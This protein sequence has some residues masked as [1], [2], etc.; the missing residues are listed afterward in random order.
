[1]NIR[2]FVKN[3][4]QTLLVIV[5]LSIIVRAALLGVMV[6]HGFDDQEEG[7][8]ARSLLNGQGYS[9]AGTPTAHKPPLYTF[10]LT[11][12]FL[13]FPSEWTPI[14]YNS[15]ILYHAHVVDQILK[16]II[17]ALTVL[18]LYSLGKKVFGQPTGLLGAFLFAINPLLAVQ[19]LFPG[20][21]P[22]DMLLFTGL[23]L[24]FVQIIQ[25][26]SPKTILVYSLVSAIT[27][28]ENPVILGFILPAQVCLFFWELR[29]SPVKLRLQTLILPFV[30]ILVLVTPWTYRNYR[31]FH[32]FVPL[33]SNF[34]LELWYGNNELATGGFYQGPMPAASQSPTYNALNEVQRN[35]IL[36]GEAVKFIQ[37]HPAAA[38]KLRIFSALY[39]WFGTWQFS[40]FPVIFT[41]AWFALNLIS[42]IA[43]VAGMLLATL[44]SWRLNIPFLLMI[45]AIFIPYVLTHSGD[46]RYRAGIMPLMMLYI[47]FLLVRPNIQAEPGGKEFV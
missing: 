20:H 29:R 2:Q 37:D 32:Q 14:N 19:I 36:G 43:G 1:M 8:I 34:P 31:V 16:I 40:G 39:F 15:A 3:E 11:A 7:I 17:A 46:D 38:L 4:R 18:V 33:T 47:A 45:I 10:I 21:M 13:P 25:E 41:K 27:V 42:I 5:L 9:F 28:L 35:Q 26:P 24:L 6:K 44:R 23:L 22:Y 12:C 30:F